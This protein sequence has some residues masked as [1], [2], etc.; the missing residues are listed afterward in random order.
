MSALV[1][2]KRNYI[3]IGLSLLVLLLFLLNT[4]GRLPYDFTARLENFS[5]DLRLT[6]TM[7]NTQDP[8]IVIVDI[9]E[10][11]LKEQGH[12]P[13]GR[14][15][16]AH[17]VDLL[18]DKYGIDVLGFDVVFAEK[19]DSS[20]LK[21]LEE[22]GRTSLAADAGFRTALEQLR[23]RLD[24]DQLFANSLKNRHVVLGYYFRQG[25]AL[26]DSVG[27]LPPPAL[28]QPGASLDNVAA[29][30]AD[31]FTANLPQL[32][33]NASGAGYF[34]I[35]LVENDGVLRRVPLLQMYQGDLYETLSLAVARLALQ[36]PQI[37][38]GFVEEAGEST[39]AGLEWL[40]LGQRRIAVDEH[41]AALIPYRGEQG[42]FPYISATDL[43][44]G[45]ISPEM[46]KG[47]IVLVG[48]TAA[49]LKDLRVTPVQSVYPGVEV[50]ANLIAGMLDQNIKQRPAYT[51]GVE[52]IS[53]LLAGLLLAIALPK[54]SPLWATV[55][56]LALACAYTA[57][58]LAVWQI[59][60]QVL[61]LASVLLMIAVLF[62]LN[63]S[64]GFFI[65]SRGKRQL[66]SRFGQYV[67]REL[68]AEMAKDPAAFTL[69]GE[70]RELTVLFSDVRDFTSIS[71]GLEP[72]QL[73]LLMNEYLT[74][75]T[76]IIHQHRGTIDK[77]MGDAI[78]AFWGAPVADPEH[79]RH[80]LLAAIDMIAALKPLQQAFEAKGW[81]PIKIGVGL[82]TG[83]MTVGNMGSE[84]RMAYTVMGDEVNLGSRLEGL[85][86]EYGVP[87]I[88]SES[89]VKAVPEFMYRELDCVRVKGKLKPV[90]IYEPVGLAVDVSAAVLEGLA[91]YCQALALY[92]QQDWGAAGEKF[93]QLLSVY[94]DCLLYKKYSERVVY[95]RDN[96]PGREW[97]G[98]FTFKTK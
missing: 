60:N 80:A 24:Y 14:D 48:T 47:A 77:Y 75:M 15:K 43:L 33:K 17:M 13:W 30:A 36:E 23:P 32:Q 68:V 52:F 31:A 91:V 12:W 3:R 92:R 29:L 59:A 37:D 95:F 4:V 16:L 27:L 11:S 46:L 65:E 62:V 28:A 1:F 19:D 45:R 26:V 69:E 55:L 93:A 67:P 56:A 96:P 22:I 8:R 86:K 71:E 97:D 7:P 89:T 40:N 81:P 41:L 6:Q 94:P 20:G 74:P 83:T 34:S 72:A 9:D 63:M 2:L 10:K 73:T 84:F 87:I 53:L 76:H 21:S 64:Y 39:Y 35:S 78:M 42:S 25:E 49:G 38:L 57:F 44:N 58:N 79:A 66:A 51:L 82:N 18:F 70:S 5:Y 88:V 98:V 85:T 90:V 54:L 50:H 61:P